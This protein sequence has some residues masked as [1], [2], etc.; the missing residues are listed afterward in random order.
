[1][2][3]YVKGGNL[4]VDFFLKLVS[5]MIIDGKYLIIECNLVVIVMFMYF[6]FFYNWFFYG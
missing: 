1:M 5:V 6:V 2:Y 4:F 3:M